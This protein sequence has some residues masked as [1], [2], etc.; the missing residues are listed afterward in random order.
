MR[1]CPQLKKSRSICRSH[2]EGR[3]CYKNLSGFQSRYSSREQ[4]R[5]RK[6]SLLHDSLLC[7]PDLF[8]VMMEILYTCFDRISINKKVSTPVRFYRFLPDLYPHLM[9]TGKKIFW[10]EGDT[11]TAISEQERPRAEGLCA[12]GVEHIHCGS[13]INRL[14]GPHLHAP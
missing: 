8:F 2:A 9:L 10:V 13:S 3:P 1:K 6:H 14:P 7:S 5:T 12:G 11:N 4:S